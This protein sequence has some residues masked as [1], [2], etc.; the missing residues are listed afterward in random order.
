M[1]EDKA[2][3]EAAAIQSFLSHSECGARRGEVLDSSWLEVR[4]SSTGII[5]HDQKWEESLL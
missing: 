3:P 2:R 4:Y 1:R 5:L